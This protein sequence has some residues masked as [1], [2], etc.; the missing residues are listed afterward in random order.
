[1]IQPEAIRQ[2]VRER[3]SEQRALV[4]RLLTLREQLSGSLFVRWG[5]CGKPGCACREGHKHGPYYVLSTRS[6]GRGSYAYVA[7]ENAET[8]RDLVK[9]HRE[10]KAGLK[11]LARLNSDLVALLKRYQ[12]AMARR[13]GRRL[14]L[15]LATS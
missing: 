5:E 9:R 3:L 6:G 4:R 13:G 2:R 14:G 12:E 11:R 1:M 8:A 10:F 7:G 15:A